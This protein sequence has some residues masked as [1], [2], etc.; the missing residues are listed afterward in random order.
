[1]ELRDTL[2]TTIGMPLLFVNKVMEIIVNTCFY[3]DNRFQSVVT[4]TS[5]C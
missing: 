5:L 3:E 1:M 4:I 2:V